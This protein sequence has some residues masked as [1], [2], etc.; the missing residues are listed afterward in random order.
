MK[1]LAF[2]FL[3]VFIIFSFISFASAAT[4]PYDPVLLSKQMGLGAK[5]ESVFALQNFLVN[6]GHL[7][8]VADGKFG[9]KTK[10]AVVAYQKANKISPTGFV[11]PLTLAAINKSILSSGENTANTNTSST[12][13][14]LSIKN[15]SP[16]PSGQ[17][18]V[19]YSLDIEGVGGTEGY[20]WDLVTGSLPLGLELMKTEIRC[21]MAPCYNWSPVNIAGV[22]YVPGVYSF[23]LEVVS[24]NEKVQKDFTIEILKTNTVSSLESANADGAKV[25]CEYA[26]PPMGYH[27]ENVKIY[28]PCG[29]TLVAD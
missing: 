22:P 17:L 23:T 11:G 24:G 18:G 27:Y 20:R 7:S 9:P 12:T 6:K 8:G 2:V 3:S 28:P 25:M 10:A 14:P 19:A 29:A 1:K 5:G 21:I 4:K 16:L 13:K 15:A 26:R